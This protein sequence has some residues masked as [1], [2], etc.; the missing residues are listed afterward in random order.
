MFIR[1]EGPWSVADLPDD[2]K[3]D[4]VFRFTITMPNKS[5]IEVDLL[6]DVDPDYDNLIEQLQSLPGQY[7]YYATLYS[8]LKSQIA[9]FERAVK[10]RRG[11]QLEYIVRT[12]SAKGV[13]LT[14]KQSQSL[15]EADDEVIKLE[16][17]LILL[18]KTCGKLYHMIEAMRLKSEHLRTLSVFRRQEYQD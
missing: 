18:N 8:E 3:N 12:S 7:T 15:L 1:L 10:T 4:T 5:K 2:L 14:D 16:A 9:T 11:K 17:K 13:K 6:A